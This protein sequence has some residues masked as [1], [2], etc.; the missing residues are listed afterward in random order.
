MPRRV[1]LSALALFIMLN[2]LFAN[3]SYKE[4]SFG[5][6]YMGA[7]SVG[8]IEVFYSP[9]R[10]WDFGFGTATAFF[11]LPIDVFGYAR[12]NVLE[13]ACSPFLQVSVLL[14]P[15]DTINLVPDWFFGRVE[16]G[17]IIR[18]ATDGTKPGLFSGVGICYQI[19]GNQDVVVPTKWQGLF[20]GI[21]GGITFAV[22]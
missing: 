14:M 8:G 20:P 13:S 18:S 12:Y 10:N 22:K 9:N 21:F 15:P 4:L 6:E 19:I 16:T 3:N 2:V 17:I 11:F 7:S 1:I 5:L